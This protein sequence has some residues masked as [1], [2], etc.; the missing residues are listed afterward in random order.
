MSS[1][2][3]PIKQAM[4]NMLLITLL[5]MSTALLG[6][7]FYRYVRSSYG[8]DDTYR[9]VAIVQTTPEKEALKT[10]YL[11]ELLD[12]SIDR[13]TN[14]HRFNAKEGR[15]RL[16]AHPLIKEASITKVR[17]GT[18][19]VDYMLRKPVA[20]LTDFTNTAID[21]EGVPFPFKPFFTP[22]KLPELYLGMASS[23]EESPL[24]GGQWGK[25]IEG[26]RMVLAHD[27]LQ[28]L[29]DHMPSEVTNLKRI[30][31][32]KAHAPSLGQRQIVLMF[33]KQIMREEKGRTVLFRIPHVL[34]L[35]SSEYINGLKHY[36][37]LLPYI[38][39]NLTLE[40]N[41]QSPVNINMPPVIIDL[42]LPQMAFF[43]NDKKLHKEKK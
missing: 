4:L 15:R 20:F 9:I 34:R 25:K 8:N 28:Y 33:E 40:I 7:I 31:V 24:H 30:D 32:S 42:R 27:V 22:K 41:E 35:H 18:L 11:A 37:L 21:M 1:E 36:V 16:L 17:P 38:N 6:L 43:T 3:M 26:P 5:V 12:L 2:K 19:H 39:K 14:L 23:T 29:F 13:P 10:V